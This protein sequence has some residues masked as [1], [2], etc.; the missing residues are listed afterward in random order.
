MPSN[1]CRPAC[2]ACAAEGAAPIT[3]HPVSQLRVTAAPSAGLSA[4]SHHGQEHLQEHLKTMFRR[5]EF[6][7]RNKRQFWRVK[8]MQTAGSQ[9]FAWV[10]WLKTFGCFAYRVYPFQIL[11]FSCSCK[12]NLCLSVP[13][14]PCRRFLAVWSTV[15]L[16]KLKVP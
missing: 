5:D 8:S 3:P 11:V 2:S 16:P 14:N 15:S 1:S 6:D 12:H 10:I 13:V 4:A 7:K 9:P